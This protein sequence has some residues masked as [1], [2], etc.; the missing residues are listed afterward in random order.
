MFS[1][2]S[3]LPVVD[4]DNISRY[5]DTPPSSP[6][7]V[8]STHT[9]LPFYSNMKCHEYPVNYQMSGRQYAKPYKEVPK[10]NNNANNDSYGK[11]NIN[12]VENFIN[13]NIDGSLP[14]LDPI[15]VDQ[16]INM[17]DYLAY[18][19]YQQ[20]LYRNQSYIP[21]HQYQQQGSMSSNYQDSL[22]TSYEKHN[23]TVRSEEQQRLTVDISNIKK[24]N[25]NMNE[26]ELGNLSPIS[27]V[28]TDSFHNLQT[29]RQNNNDNNLTLPN[30][31]PVEDTKP[32][33]DIKS[34]TEEDNP[35]NFPEQNPSFFKEDENSNA[36]QEF[37]PLQ[38]QIKVENISDTESIPEE[39]YLHKTIKVPKP[40]KKP[41][42]PRLFKFLWETLI[43]KN[44]CIEWVDESTGTFKFLDSKRIAHLW[45]LRKNKP[46]MQYENFARS[47]RTYIKKGIL[48]KPRNK[49]V[50]RFA[51]L[52]D[53]DI[54]ANIKMI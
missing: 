7:S 31:S 46:N 48:T 22:P 8:V 30:Q 41:G 6:D 47:L 39:K 26:F 12:K 45:G 9:Q 51:K 17:N 1:G 37:S 14:N 53:D 5:Q 29:P 34:F 16:S 27:T 24:K 11:W 52:P 38:H 23:Y 36:S 4:L 33:R 25:Y 43:D 10:Y 28:S 35:L 13:I 42:K 18:E 54:K 44:E 32:T 40:G 2:G 15:D 49:L 21:N 3:P 50:Y 20:L 19:R